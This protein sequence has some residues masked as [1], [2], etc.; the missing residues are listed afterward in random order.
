MRNLNARV[1]FIQGLFCAMQ[2]V[3]IVY[4]VQAFQ[5]F[6]YD[7]T[8]IG[9]IMML[10]AIVLVVA[11]PFWGFIADKVSRNKPIVMIGAGISVILYFLFIFSGGNKLV[12]ILAAMGM[13]ALYQPMMHLMDAWISKLIMD[14][15][16]INYGATRTGGSVFYAITSLAFGIVVSRYGMQLAPF[17]C[18]GIYLVMAAFMMG[19]PDTKPSAKTEKIS[20][21][22][23]LRYL[24]GNGAFMVFVAAYFLMS[25]TTVPSNTYYSVVLYGMGGNEFHVGVAQ[26]LQAMCEIPVM[27]SFNLMR[28]KTGWSPRTFLVI[29]MV[30]YSIKTVLLA[31]AP[32]AGMVLAASV[33]QGM[34]YAIFLPATIAYLM[35]NVKRDYLS[36]AQM[37]SVSIGASLA[38]IVLNPVCGAM[39][40]AMGTQNMLKLMFVFALAAAAMLMLTGRKRTKM[41]EG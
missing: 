19:L 6:G 23:S 20:V 32:G 29:S 8:L 31:F 13:Y 41:M 35:E 16:S 11:Q 4:F 27:L 26:F 12:V 36:T 28:R 14:G 25:F 24:K 3:S 39:A 9:I 40:D 2:S 30:G 21:K 1:F 10:T 18:A 34:S 5:R 38:S 22:N 15:Y 17:I 33:F 37:L 7:N